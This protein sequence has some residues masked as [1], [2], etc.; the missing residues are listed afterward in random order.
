[1]FAKKKDEKSVATPEI[2]V[3]QFIK[4]A[5]RA[6]ILGTPAAFQGVSEDQLY[7][8]WFCKTL[9]NWKALISTNALDGQY[10]EVTYDGDKRQSYVDHYIRRSN[11]AVADSQLAFLDRRDKR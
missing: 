10:F 11:K 1:M 4:K 3:D 2:D 6:V 9:K 5:K 8:V 7:V